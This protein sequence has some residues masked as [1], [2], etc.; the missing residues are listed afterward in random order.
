ML[1]GLAT[2]QS[3]VRYCQVTLDNDQVVYIPVASTDRC[4]IPRPEPTLLTAAAVARLVAV[5]QATPAA[6]RTRHANREQPTRLGPPDRGRAEG[7]RRSDR[8]GT[9]PGGGA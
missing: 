3:H 6:R 7:G 4:S 2:L 5:F 1:V 9:R 8:P